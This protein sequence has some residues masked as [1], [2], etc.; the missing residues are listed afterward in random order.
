MVD[1]K[2]KKKILFL[3][4]IINKK[5]ENK[6]K[7]I[8]KSIFQNREL[9]QIKILFSKVLISNLNNKKSRKNC[10]QG[11]SEKSIDK[12]SKFSR[13]FLHKINNENLNQNFKIYEK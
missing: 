3:K 10:I 12:K 11:I 4:N 5:N 8:L 2:R 9:N 6:K 1:K 13:F 7:I